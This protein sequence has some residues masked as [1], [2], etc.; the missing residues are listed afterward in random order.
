MSS[1]FDFAQKVVLIAGGTGGLGRALTTELR[2]RGCIVATVSRT[3]STDP[4]HFVADLRSPESAT[5]VINEV[6]AKHGALNIVINAM[7]VVA[8]GEIGATSVD[9]IEEVFLTNTFGHIFF[10][11]AALR[12]VQKESVLVGISGVI[13]EQNLPGMSVYGA[14]KA[15][16]RSFD[17]ALAREA[18]KAGVRVIDARPPH[19]ETGLASRAVAG[20]APKF[21]VGL[22]P[23]AVARRIVQAIAYGETDLPSTAFT[24]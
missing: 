22:D 21:P 1:A 14:S 16:V 12:H 24:N 3:A 6:V 4:T 20:T 13:A 5:A 9:T 11:Q 2:S 7:G 18:R 23:I 10:M 15:A 17:E 8:F 19:T